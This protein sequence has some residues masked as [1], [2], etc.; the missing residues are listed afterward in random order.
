MDE[1]RDVGV[2]HGILREI[3]GFPTGSGSIPHIVP[4]VETPGYCQTSSGRFSFPYRADDARDDSHL[5]FRYN[6]TFL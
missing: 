1:F 5:Y 4:G 3:S 6:L 2:R